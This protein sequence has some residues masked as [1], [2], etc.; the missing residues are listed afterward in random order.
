MRMADLASDSGAVV[1]SSPRGV[2][3]GNEVLSW[4]RVGH[5]DANKILPALLITKIDPL[6]FKET[7][8]Y[9]APADNELRDLL[10][11]PLRNFCTSEDQF[12]EAIERIFSDLKKGSELR[13]FEVAQHDVNSKSKYDAVRRA[14]NA[15]EL[16]PNFFGLGVDLRK[17]FSL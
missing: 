14:G 3:F 2:H 9:E 6:Y 10:V 1:I 16:K 12:V 15:I 7:G 4:H 17:L 8:A 11:I 13:N 5:L